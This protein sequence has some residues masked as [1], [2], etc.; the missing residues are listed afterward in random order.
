LTSPAIPRK[1]TLL[2]VSDKSLGDSLTDGVDLGHLSTA[3]DA[4]THVDA[5]K[6]ILK[7]YEYIVLASN[8]ESFIFDQCARNEHEFLCAVSSEQKKKSKPCQGGGWARAT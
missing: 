6:A 8:Q 7:K 3:L 4:H 5:R 1:L 2:V